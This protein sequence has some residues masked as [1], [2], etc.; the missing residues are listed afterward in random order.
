MTLIRKLGE[1]SKPIRGKDYPTIP[2]LILLVFVVTGILA[3]LLVLHS[4]TQVSLGKM[5][6]PP[7]FQKGGDLKYPLGTDQLG[8]DIFSRIILGARVSM[9]VAITAILLAGT[10]GVAVGLFA[11]YIGRP[12]DDILMRLTDAQLSV[13][14]ILLAIVVIGIFSPSLLNVVVVIGITSW[15]RYAR[16]ARS[17]AINVKQ[18]DFVVYAKVAGASPL[19]I[20]WKHIL[21]NLLPSIIVLVTLDIPR[22][23]LFESALSF[24]GL[25][26]P[27]P[28]PSWGGMIAEGRSYLARAWWLTVMPGIYLL[29]ISLSANLSGDWLRDKLDPSLQM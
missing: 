27:P 18:E 21:P 22:V 5:L 20:M 15:P 6:K 24:L 11:G 10:V 4:P 28:T 13:P 7:F 9:I 29:L 25:G 1:W 23:I 2:F 26:V 14:M 8:R 17:E 16:L 19:R 12:A 3:P